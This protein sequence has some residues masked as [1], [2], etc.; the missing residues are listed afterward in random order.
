MFCVE[1]E[2][3]GPAPHQVDAAITAGK[4][5]LVHCAW[6]Q[7]RSCAI[8]CAFAV[9]HRGM[10]AIDAIAYV[11]ERNL[12]ERRYAGQ[13]PPG[14]A[15]HNKAFREIIAEIERERDAAQPPAMPMA[16]PQATGLSQP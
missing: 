8:C 15:M 7:N 16:A 1:S 9:L 3:D 14:G 12:I 2:A 4:A 5:V 11:R 10:S 13:H 6:G